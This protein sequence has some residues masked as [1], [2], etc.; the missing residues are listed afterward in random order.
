MKT[1][2]LLSTAFASIKKA[3]SEM[4]E[5]LTELKEIDSCLAE[6][7]KINTSLSKAQLKQIGNDAFDIASKYGKQASDYLSSVKSL[8][9]A[10]YDSAG[11]LAKLSTA[12]QSAGNMTGDLADNYIM[13]TDKAYQLGGSVQQ[14]QNIMD[15]AANIADNHSI[16]LN[17]LADG[18]TIVGSTASEL[19][20]NVDEAT[21]ALATMMSVTHTS[22]TEAADAL[23]NIL[24]HI[25][26]VADEEAGIDTSSLKQYEEACA[27]L[28]VSLEETKNGVLSLRD[29]MSVLHD[30]AEAYNSLPDT[31][32]RKSNLLDSMGNTTNA[33]QLDAFLREYATY[34]TMLQEYA[35][36]AGSLFQAAEAEKFTYT[37]YAIHNC[38]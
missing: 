22:G 32:S 4:R 3:L 30:L 8:A 24:L 29:P 17:E 20:V 25:R 2:N 10:G 36:G 31:D 34:E 12:M 6:I 26:Q 16:Q 27:A 38:K 7:R 15:G 37:S 14:L 18:M 5:T 23:E 9:K 19:G 21:A 28:N 33:T 13:A 1:M 11:S 35:S